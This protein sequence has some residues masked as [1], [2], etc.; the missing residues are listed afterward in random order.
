[1]QLRDRCKGLDVPTWP[2]RPHLFA[3]PDSCNPSSAAV[4]FAVRVIHNKCIA[5]HSGVQH[6]M[7]LSSTRV[8]RH[9]PSCAPC[10]HPAT[11]LRPVTRSLSYG[12]RPDGI[13]CDIRTVAIQARSTSGSGD[14]GMSEEG[15]L[16]SRCATFR[17]HQHLRRYEMPCIH[18][19]DCTPGLRPTPDGRACTTACPCP[20]AEL[21]AS[22]LTA[23]P[24]T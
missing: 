24:H 18:V 5:S 7:M 10:S 23:R 4:S 19:L 2:A 17:P 22:L 11:S 13:S 21:H 6:D 8:G 12:R 9:G 14:I 20:R 16:L 1:M 3:E 15:S